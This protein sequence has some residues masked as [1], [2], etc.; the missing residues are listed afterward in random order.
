MLAMSCIFI[1][2]AEG[3]FFFFFFPEL[4]IESVISVIETGKF[5]T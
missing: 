1:C 2:G 3:D 4:R 5:S